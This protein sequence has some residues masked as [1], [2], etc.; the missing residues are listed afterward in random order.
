MTRAHA[1]LG[2]ALLALA[3]WLG[4]H[5]S[6]LTYYSSLG[7]GPGFFPLWLC[8]ALAAL[9]ASIVASALRS[10]EQ[11]PGGDFAP[12][13]A[14]IARLLVVVCALGA[15]VPG[16]EVLGFRLAM[17][18]FCIVLLLALGCRSPLQFAIATAAGSLGA[19]ALFADALGVALPAGRLGF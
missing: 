10:R 16:L 5:A 11:V 3:A 8:I 2:L 19:H 17:A 14:G 13:R 18:A 7:P 9:A 1:P 12:P 4:W 15:L 6:R